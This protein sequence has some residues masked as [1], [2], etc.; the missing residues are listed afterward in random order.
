MSLSKRR[1]GLRAKTGHPNRASRLRERNYY[2]VNP[3]VIWYTDYTVITKLGQIEKY[4]KGAAAIL[5]WS[6]KFRVIRLGAPLSP[7]TDDGEKNGTADD[8]SIVHQTTKSS[9]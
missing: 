9:T 2:F 7:P 8:A 1:N 3:T 5:K 4:Q 6:V